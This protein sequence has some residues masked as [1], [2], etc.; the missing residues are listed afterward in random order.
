MHVHSPLSP[1]SYCHYA[2]II[3]TEQQPWSVHYYGVSARQY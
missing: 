3:I 1:L 2:R